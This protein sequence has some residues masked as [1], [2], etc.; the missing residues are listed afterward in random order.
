MRR[1]IDDELKRDRQRQD[2]YFEYLNENERKNGPIEFEEVG[3]FYDDFLDVWN[4]KDTAD[5]VCYPMTGENMAREVAALLSHYD[6][7]LHAV[8]DE[9]YVKDRKLEE[10]GVSIDV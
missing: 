2:R 1:R 10:L 8:L 9:L 7:R 6:G 3:L 5:G 4:V